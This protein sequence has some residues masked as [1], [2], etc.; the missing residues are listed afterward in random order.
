[1]SETKQLLKNYGDIETPLYYAGDVG[2]LLGIKN[3][4][5]MILRVK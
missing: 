5:R 3:L 1:M 4:L 2:K